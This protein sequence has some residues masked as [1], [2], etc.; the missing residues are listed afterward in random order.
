MTQAVRDNKPKVWD[1]LLCRDDIPVNG[2]CTLGKAHMR[3]ACGMRIL[4]IV[5]RLIEKG[6]DSSAESRVDGT[7]GDMLGDDYNEIKEYLIKMCGLR[8]PETPILSPS[9]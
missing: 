3:H 2:E 4:E 1:M 5:R 6:G 8:F 9:T 7:P